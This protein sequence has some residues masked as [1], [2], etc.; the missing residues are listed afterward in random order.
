[1][2]WGSL[3]DWHAVP[4]HRCLAQNLRFAV[5]RWADEDAA[6]A[7][8]ERPFVAQT[9]ARAA[10]PPGPAIPALSD[11]GVAAR[12]EALL[13]GEPPKARLAGAAMLT[14]ATTASSGMTSALVQLHHLDLRPEQ[15]LRQPIARGDDHHANRFA[16]T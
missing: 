6:A 13:K 8:G 14:N 12:V 7:I 11:V 16:T 5:E 2:R 4:L 1:M 3:V 15:A 9:I 10:L